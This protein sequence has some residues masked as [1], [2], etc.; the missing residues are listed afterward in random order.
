MLVPFGT[1]VLDKDDKSVGTVSRL[2]LHPESREVSAPTVSG[3][4]AYIP[5]PSVSLSCLD[6]STVR[7]SRKRCG[8][9]GRAP[10]DST[11]LQLGVVLLG[12]AA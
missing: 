12:V 9:N 4:P 11:L 2:V 5:G 10:V 1:H 6:S 3:T 8:A 7:E